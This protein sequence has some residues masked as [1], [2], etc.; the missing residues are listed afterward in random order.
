LR[1]E[2]HA[3]WQYF[4]DR[5]CLRPRVHCRF[6]S[7]HGHIFSHSSGGR[8]EGEA[9]AETEATE[10]GC[11]GDIQCCSTVTP[12]NCAR[13]RAVDAIRLLPADQR[14][15]LLRARRVLP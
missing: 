3:D 4:T 7:F 11:I 14:G 12:D 6:R 13:S 15:E 1:R 9:Q 8:Y 10:D 2:F 5:Q